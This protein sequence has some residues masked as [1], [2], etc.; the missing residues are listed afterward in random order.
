MEE[1]CSVTSFCPFWWQKDAEWKESRRRAVLWHLGKVSYQ[2]LAEVQWE[3]IC[4]LLWVLCSWWPLSWEIPSIFLAGLLLGSYSTVLLCHGLLSF[5]SVWKRTFKKNWYFCASERIRLVWSL[6]APR[7]PEHQGKAVL[8]K[9]EDKHRAAVSKELT[10][11]SHLP[12][13]E[14]QS[15]VEQKLQHVYIFAS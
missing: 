14:F 13:V 6:A 10:F 5:F 11:I 3:R 12:S 7:P 4:S 8:E 1:F 2:L 9:W 15:P